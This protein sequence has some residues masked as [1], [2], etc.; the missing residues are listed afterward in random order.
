M[1]IPHQFIVSQSTWNSAHISATLLEKQHQ[2]PTKGG[3]ESFCKVQKNILFP[4][5]VSQQ[6]IS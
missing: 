2:L 6:E 4:T 5:V 3:R 1:K